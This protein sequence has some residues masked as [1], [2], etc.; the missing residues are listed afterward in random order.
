M[1]FGSNC[2]DAED[3]DEKI[4]RVERPA[5]EASDESVALRRCEPT[6]VAEKLHAIFLHRDL[7][8]ASNSIAST[9]NGMRAAKSSRDIEP[10]DSKEQRQFP[11]GYLIT[12]APACA[13]IASWSLL[14]PETPIAP[15]M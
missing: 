9:G 5:Q 14:S 15:I 10:R 12:F 8:D 3:Q 7:K 4:E 2:I 6:K 11:Q 1:K 13:Q